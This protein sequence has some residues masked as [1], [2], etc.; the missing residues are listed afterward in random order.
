LSAVAA[1]WFVGM[2]GAALAIRPDSVVAFGPSDKIISSIIAS[3]GS[4]LDAGKWLVWPII[5]RGCGRS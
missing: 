5:G 3:D 2:A 4:L 1:L